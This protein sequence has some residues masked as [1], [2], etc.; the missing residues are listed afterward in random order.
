MAAVA[1]SGT[2]SLSSI[3]YNPDNTH[4]VASGLKA[5]AAIGPADACYINASGQVALATG[6]AA[7]AAAKV[8]G[9][10]AMAASAGEA[11]TLYTEVEF[12]YGAGLTPGTDLYLSGT[13][14]GGLDTAVSTGG[15]APIGF[16]VDAVRVRLFA[17]RY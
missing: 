14:P 5:A 8:R 10:A 2:P 7:N 1:K 3:I 9:F 11:V 12:R 16:V 17:S 6:A 15:T 4:V 13:T